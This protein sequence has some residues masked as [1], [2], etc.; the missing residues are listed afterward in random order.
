MEKDIT[1][2]YNHGSDLKFTTE[3][4]KTK[5]GVGN[6]LID[7]MVMHDLIQWLEKENNSTIRIKCK[8]SSDLILFRNQ[9]KYVLIEK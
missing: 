4:W 2:V 8:N 6:K 1:I 3:E 9:I 7:I 5:N